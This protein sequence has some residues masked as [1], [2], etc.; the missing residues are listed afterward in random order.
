MDWMKA[1]A[2]QLAETEL[3]TRDFLLGSEAL[4]RKKAE[5]K[6]VVCGLVGL[7]NGEKHIAA[8]MLILK[9]PDFV[10]CIHTFE[11][12]DTQIVAR[13]REQGVGSQVYSSHDPD[14]LEL[15]HVSDLRRH[16]PMLLQGILEHFWAIRPAVT[17]ILFEGFHVRTPE[18]VTPAPL[19]T[20]PEI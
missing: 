9:S 11:T 15:R 19:G 3:M 20:A 12:G 8:D 2:Q 16:L 5:I 6:R 7:I 10:W 4:D 1:N 13:R 18:P 14:R 17:L